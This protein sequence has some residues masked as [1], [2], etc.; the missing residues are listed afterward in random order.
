[1]SYNIS[2]DADEDI[3]S[4][5]HHET[6]DLDTADGFIEDI[7]SAVKKHQCYRI[8]VDYRGIELIGTITKI[9]D[10]PKKV[11]KALSKA[12][13]RSHA[14]KR[15]LVVSG[16]TKGFRFLETV[17]ITRGQPL[18]IFQDIDKAKK[19]LTEEK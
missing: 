16:Y 2:Y 13:L 12:G 3:L 14:I 8:L 1:M 11:S 4:V 17:S 10:V 19:W 5:T 9:Y 7:L 15:A 6:F 18:R